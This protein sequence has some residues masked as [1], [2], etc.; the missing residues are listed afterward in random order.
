M[1][2]QSVAEAEDP[3]DSSRE[4]LRAAAVDNRAER[5]DALAVLP[6]RFELNLELTEVLA[7]LA[8]PLAHAVVTPGGGAA[9]RRGHPFDLGVERDE[10]RVLVSVRER[11]EQPV[12]DREL[13]VVEGRAAMRP[14]CS[15]RHARRRNRGLAVVR[16]RGQRLNS[17][18]PAG[19]RGAAE[20][21]LGH[22]M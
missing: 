13:R 12:H 18:R 22:P 17:A 1:D 5:Q 11:S 20:I 9:P 4:R 15:E 16:A 14:P 7:E 19:R 10:D 2:D 8:H 21:G 6:E 3:A